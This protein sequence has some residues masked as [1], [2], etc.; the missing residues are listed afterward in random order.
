MDKA[1]QFFQYSVKISQELLGLEN[2][3]SANNYHNIGTRYWARGN[4]KM[5]IWFAEESYKI[6]MKTKGPENPS[7]IKM[8]KNLNYYKN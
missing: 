2:I 5:A 3:F 7:T 1:F 6:L 8:L 4:K